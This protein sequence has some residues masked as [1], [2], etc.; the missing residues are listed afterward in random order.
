MLLITAV[1]ILWFGKSLLGC[2][3]SIKASMFPNNSMFVKSHVQSNS[4][5]I[6]APHCWPL[7]RQST[8]YQRIP[9]TKSDV[10]SLFMLYCHVQSSSPRLV[11]WS[12][13]CSLTPIHVGCIQWSLNEN[14]FPLRVSHLG[15][16]LMETLDPFQL[17]DHEDYF[18]ETAD[19]ILDIFIYIIHLH[20]HTPSP[21]WS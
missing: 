17:S 16:K 7:V 13:D 20:P 18:R 12:V 9:L 5:D 19:M 14:R 21:V 11:F 6:K 3:M 15:F 1:N 8:G 2:H 4:K 10:K